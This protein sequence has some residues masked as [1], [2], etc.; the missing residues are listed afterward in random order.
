MDL[1]NKNK[2]VLLLHPSYKSD[3]LQQSALALTAELTH[4]VD[5]VDFGEASPTQLSLVIKTCKRG[6]ERLMKLEGSLSIIST[7]SINAEKIV[8][9]ALTVLSQRLND[10]IIE[11]KNRTLL[12]DSKALYQYISEIDSMIDLCLSWAN[13]ESSEPEQ[14]KFNLILDTDD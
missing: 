1:I 6:L 12:G 7:D 11:L 3:R 8:N 4:L 10:A 2:P 5:N 14:P 13:G 9:D